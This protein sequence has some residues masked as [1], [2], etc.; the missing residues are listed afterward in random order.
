MRPGAEGGVRT[1]PQRPDL[2]QGAL[3]YGLMLALMA[4]VAVLAL[5]LFGTQ[6]SAIINAFAK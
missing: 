1:D 5:T 6:V 2:G 3:E 4:I